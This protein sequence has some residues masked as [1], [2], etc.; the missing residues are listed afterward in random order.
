[1]SFKKPSRTMSVPTT[2]MDWLSD[3][4]AQGLSAAQTLQWLQ[5]WTA[6]GLLRHIDSALAAQLLR[7]DG[8]ASPALLV[9]AAMLAQ[10][11]GRGHTCLPLADLC[12]P[13]V[14]MLAWPTVAVDGPQG[15]RALWAH[16]P[17]TLADWQAAL[18][19]STSRAC[20]RLSDAP[21]QGQ[22]LV[23]GGTAHAPLLYL[24]RY[25]GYEQRVG[26]GLLQRASELL[27][28][29][30]AAARRWLDR[31]FVPSSQA[32]A[33][34]DWQKVACAVALRA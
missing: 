13:P 24:R 21:D 12:A 10:M 17:A 18:Q 28:V 20:Y 19:S 27:P 15:L 34:T 30:E 29:P 32:S 14:A 23:L 1:M 4:P 9:A 2:Q 5:L 6:Q 33:E 16:L 11:E 22:P 3:L 25:A 31:F 7:L 26:Q 8:Q